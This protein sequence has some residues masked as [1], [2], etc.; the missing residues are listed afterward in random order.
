[1]NKLL[2][3]VK[4]YQYITGNID[5]YSRLLG[6]HLVQSKVN[7][8]ISVPYIFPSPSSPLLCWSVQI[9]HA[10]CRLEGECLSI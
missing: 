6:L 2:Q 10:Y 8:P 3:A 7:F 5:K 4:E 1:M 9:P